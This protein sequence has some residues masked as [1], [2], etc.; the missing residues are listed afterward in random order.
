MVDLA[1]LIL[2]ITTYIHIYIYNHMQDP[3][4]LHW[5][6]TGMSLERWIVVGGNYP[7]KKNISALWIVTIYPEVSASGWIHIRTE[8]QF[9]GPLQEKNDRPESSLVV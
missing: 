9:F 1:I 2:S 8:D 5:C 7:Q 4:N 6:F 3:D